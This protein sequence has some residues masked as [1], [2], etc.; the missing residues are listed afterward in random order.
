MGYG[1]P[2]MGYGHPQQMGHH[3]QMGMGH[4]Q[5][6]YG[7]PQMGMGGHHGFNAQAA[8]WNMQAMGGYKNWHQPQGSHFQPMHLPRDYVKANADNIFM[9]YDTD[10]SGQL[11][12]NEAM[13]AI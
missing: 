12:A 9:M 4:P 5:M 6:G 10:R 7:Q 11:D 3:P 1:Q 2:Q 13:M 8:G